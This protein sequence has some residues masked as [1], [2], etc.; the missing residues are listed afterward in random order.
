MN[1]RKNRR[2]DGRVVFYAVRVVSKES[3][4]LVLPRT[5]C[6]PYP[7]PSCSWS[8]YYLQRPVNKNTFH[9]SSSLMLDIKF[10]RL[11]CR[12]VG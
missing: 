9:L 7:V 12:K 6:F 3:R 5:S 8:K 2:I 1:T 4:Q 10:S 11:L